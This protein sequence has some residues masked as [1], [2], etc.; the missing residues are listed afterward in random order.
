[1][2][3]IGQKR[4]IEE[5]N[6][7]LPQIKENK[8]NMHFLLRGKSGY[9]KTL[10]GLKIC[11]YLSY[12]KYQYVFADNIIKPYQGFSS[13]F[14]DEI[15]LLENPEF[16][17]KWLDEKEK[18][19]IFATNEFADLKEPLVNRCT[20]FTF[21]DY[22]EEELLEIVKIYINDNNYTNEMLTLVYRACNSNPRKISNLCSRLRAI[23]NQIPITNID[24]LNYVI[25]KIIGIKDG[26]DPL[27]RKYLEI[28]KI[29]GKSSL[30]N[31]SRT[32]GI[33]KAVIQSEIEPVLLYKGLISITS[34]GRSITN[35]NI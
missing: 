19:F 8:L 13:M 16:L 35:V 7:I 26:L 23:G 11:T 33:S 4:I 10:L 6:I 32:A 21:E 5:L 22:L 30:E 34:K 24:E 31:I 27:C 29:L 25:E 2:I 20:V 28:L 14:I 9:G 1:M 12:D 18:T 3:F 17:Y 15:H